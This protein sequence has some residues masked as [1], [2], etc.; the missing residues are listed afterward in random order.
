MAEICFTVEAII[1]AIVILVEYHYT[2]HK[3]NMLQ[4]PHFSSGNKGSAVLLH[5]CSMHSVLQ[6]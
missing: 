3:Y 1:E 4:I 6:C 5:R 2:A